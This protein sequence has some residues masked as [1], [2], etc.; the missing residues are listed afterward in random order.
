MTTTETTGSDKLDF[1]CII[2]EHLV[3]LVL[4][5]QCRSVIIFKSLLLHFYKLLL[6]LLPKT[7]V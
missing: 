7:K 6:A 3:Y 2:Y 5:L 4:L 1:I